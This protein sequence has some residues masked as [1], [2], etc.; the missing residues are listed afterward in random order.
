MPRHLA[1]VIQR[2]PLR[3]TS[4]HSLWKLAADGSAC[5]YERGHRNRR[6]GSSNRC[7]PRSAQPRDWRNCTHPWH[8]PQHLPLSGAVRVDGCATTALEVGHSSL[9][10]GRCFCRPADLE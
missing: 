1:Q 3:P 9:A 7:A 8:R 4:M 5:A 6:K 10:T 2:R